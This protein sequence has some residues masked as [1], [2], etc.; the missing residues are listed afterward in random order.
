VAKWISGRARGAVPALVGG[1]PGAA[2]A[3]KG[4]VRVVFSFTVTDAGRI[5]AINLIG[6][7]AVLP[8][9]EVV[10]LRRQ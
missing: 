6:D 5:A 1:E 2:W 4:T 7:P 9:L 3:V 8:E 10:L